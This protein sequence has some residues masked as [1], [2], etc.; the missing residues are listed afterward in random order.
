MN[1]FRHLSD[2]V[3]ASPQISL[4]DIAAAHAQGV[5]LIICNR[6]D[7]EDKGQL[8][9]TAIQQATCFDVSLVRP[10]MDMLAGKNS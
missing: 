10:A 9:S 1:Q 5:S 3:M 7:D 6:R 2:S 4:G 8:S